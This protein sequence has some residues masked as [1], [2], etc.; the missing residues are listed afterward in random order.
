MEAAQSFC[1]FSGG[2]IRGTMKRGAAHI[3]S[4]LTGLSRNPE[5]IL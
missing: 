2:A 1:L 3:L 5:V 4:L